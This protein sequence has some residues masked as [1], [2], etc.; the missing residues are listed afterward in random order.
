MHLPCGKI[1]S[2]GE[3]DSCEPAIM[4]IRSNNFFTKCAL[5][6]DIGLGEAYVDGDWDTNDICTVISWFILNVKKSPSKS[7]KAA[8][9]LLINSLGIINRIR[10][11]F[12]SNTL[13]NS[14]KNTFNGNGDRN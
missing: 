4:R 10:H 9:S 14:K 3:D 8:R 7:L 13:D 6:G 5:Y 1:I 12:R 2:Y 11:K